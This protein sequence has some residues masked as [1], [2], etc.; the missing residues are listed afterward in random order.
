M[1]HVVLT[2]FVS[3][4]RPP[5]SQVLPQ[6]ILLLWFSLKIHGFDFFYA[7]ISTSLIF[8]QYNHV[9]KLTYCN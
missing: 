5:S 4:G 1:N 2:K 8:M 7:I 9:Y 6:I 3:Y